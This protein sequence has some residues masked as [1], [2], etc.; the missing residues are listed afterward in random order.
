MFNVSVKVNRNQEV[1][2]VVYEDYVHSFTDI[3][4]DIVDVSTEKK[5]YSGANAQ[6]LSEISRNDMTHKGCR[7]R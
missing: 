3:H 5:S 4:Y 1:H 7:T 2:V 6:S